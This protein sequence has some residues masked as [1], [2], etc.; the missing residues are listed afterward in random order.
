MLN[1]EEK[2]APPLKA[3]PEPP[4]KPFVVIGTPALYGDVCM[5]YLQ[6]VLMMT[7]LF[8]AAG[9]D[10][11][12]VLNPGDPYLAKVRNAMVT[13]AFTEYPQFTHL[14]F[15]DADVGFDPKAALI[16]VKAD[17]DV[18]AG[19]Y[20]KKTDVPE[21]PCELFLEST[22]GQIISSNGWCKANAVP[23]GFLCIK[24]HV[25]E[26]MAVGRGVYRDLDGK[27]K[28]NIFQQGFFPPEG[29]KTVGDWWG[30][31]YAFCR[32]WREM[33]GEIWV[34]P[35]I[36]FTHTGPK[37]WKGNFGPSVKAFMEGKAKIRDVGSAAE[38]A[39]SVPP[40]AGV[41]VPTVLPAELAERTEPVA[42]VKP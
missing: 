38:P 24:R 41:A 40:A 30:E 18:A 8:E 12:F 29:E 10:W 36:D 5:T 27:E 2:H 31:D 4:K 42:G 7:K 9:I 16:L 25:L 14:F 37:T 6:S 13:R 3:I 35:D 34:W 15:I 19:I 22:D 21:F 17:L 23:T 1:G 28:Y 11:A 33:G 32:Q 26:R 20:P 39:A